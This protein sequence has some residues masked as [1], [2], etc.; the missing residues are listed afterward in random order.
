MLGLLLSQLDRL[1][2]CLSGASLVE[3]GVGLLFVFFLCVNKARP[4]SQCQCACLGAIVVIG[5]QISKVARNHFAKSSTLDW[6]RVNSAP[7]HDEGNE[8]T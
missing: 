1:S 3:S 2:H 4:L 8:K 5:E 7:N 6:Q